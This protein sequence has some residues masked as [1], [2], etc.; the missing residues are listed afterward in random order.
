MKS[1]NFLHFQPCLRLLVPEQ[2]VDTDV[3]VLVSDTSALAVNL[4]VAV[5]EINEAAIKNF[6]KDSC[7]KNRR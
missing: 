5:E 2:L 3:T 4:T 6:C 1:N 7:A